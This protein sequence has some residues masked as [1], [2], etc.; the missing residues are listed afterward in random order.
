M[1][2]SPAVLALLATTAAAVPMSANL[3]R[4]KTLSSTFGDP[5]TV[6]DPFFPLPTAEPTREVEPTTTLDHDKIFTLIKSLVATT[7]SRHKSNEPI[8][9]P[10]VSLPTTTS[11]R[12][13]EIC[14][15]PTGCRNETK[16]SRPFQTHTPSI[17]T[18]ITWGSQILFPDP[19][20]TTTPFHEE[21]YLSLPTAKPTSA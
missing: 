6:F 5:T 20:P 19:D 7:T 1:K 8:T 4:G 17:S 12:S 3:D 16:H 14:I 18:T 11:T 21:T 10:I 15:M 13:F 9:E 2:I